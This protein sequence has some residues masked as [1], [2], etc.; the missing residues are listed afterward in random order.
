MESLEKE[1][2]E[3]KKRNAWVEED[4][5]WETSWSRRVSLALITYI[6]ISFYMIYL[7]VEK[8]WLNAIIPTA[9][10][11]IFTFTLNWVRILWS[12]IRKK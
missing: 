12:K 9:G 11:I 8:P 3:I 7:G 10:F 2:K 5:A 6:L 1:I 4:K